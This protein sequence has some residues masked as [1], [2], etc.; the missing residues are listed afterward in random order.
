[1]ELFHL[2]GM[3]FRNTESGHTLCLLNYIQSCV[4]YNRRIWTHHA[5]DSILHEKNNQTWK[6]GEQ[7]TRKLRVGWRPQSTHRVEMAAF[8]R[9]F[10][11]DGK[12]SPGCWGWGVHAHP[13]SLY[14]PSRT[15]LQCTL[16]LRGQIHT[17]YFFHL[18]PYMY[19][20]VAALWKLPAPLWCIPQRLSSVHKLE[21]LLIV[22][23]CSR[24]C[25]PVIHRAILLRIYR[26]L[27]THCMLVDI[28]LTVKL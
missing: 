16:Q 24:H 27:S 18:Y 12:I 7:C 3:I 17:S 11:H 8:W 23:G 14:L 9:T 26:R 21:R 15:K 19:S 13:L 2:D 28:P 20:V 6:V 1:M 4:L 22:W 10:H 25:V 5:F